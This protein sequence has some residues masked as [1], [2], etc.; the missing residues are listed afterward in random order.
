M[1][2]FRRTLT[3]ALALVALTLSL[4]HCTRD[5][6]LDQPPAQDGGT[7]QLIAPELDAGDAQAVG[8]TSYCPTNKCPEG[9][10]T[11]PNSQF[12]CDVDL[13]TDRS[14]C[15]ACGFACP[16]S[17]DEE[18]FECIEGRCELTCGTGTPPLF[19]CDGL[20]DNGCETEATTN[21][22]CGACG[23]VCTDPA[24]PCAGK[25]SGGGFACGCAPT[26]L[27]CPAGNTL[28]CVNGMSDDN[29]CGACKNKCPEALEGITPPPNT[30]FGCAQG[31]CGG[32]DEHGNL[33][34][35]KCVTGYAD[36]DNDLSNGCETALMSPDNC[37]ACGEK[38]SDEQFC[39]LQVIGQKIQCMCPT[40]QTFCGTTPIGNCVNITTDIRNCGNCGVVCT[41][42]MGPFS[43]AVCNHGV[44]SRTCQNGRAD[45]NGNSDDECEVNT[46]SDPNNC[47][48]CGRSCDVE[49]GQACVGGQCVV[50]PCDQDAGEVTAR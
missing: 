2:P 6:M 34:G 12:P 16:K 42:M 35:L 44:C 15:G 36:C 45:C 3:P 23:V 7:G 19:D 41:D 5:V 26:E 49:L 13:R 17:T 39:G 50:E 22:H 47:G 1:I 33:F 31:K 11:C 14:N 9:H 20:P 37:G 21:E 46:D 30:R 27:Y 32:R 29:N 28:Q 38:C 10:T 40:G 18:A 24:K 4:P 43:Q 48:A 25:K 8:L